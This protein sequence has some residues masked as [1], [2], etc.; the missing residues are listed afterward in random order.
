MDDEQQPLLLQDVEPEL[1]QIASDRRPIG[2]HL[3]PEAIQS[4][5]KVSDNHGDDTV[6]PDHRPRYLTLCKL[7]GSNC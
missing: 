1:K 2:E 4:V 3:Q 7:H 5:A 6:L